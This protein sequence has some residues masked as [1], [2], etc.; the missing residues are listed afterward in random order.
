MSWVRIQIFGVLVAGWC[1]SSALV[2]AQDDSTA[3]APIAVDPVDVDAQVA[4]DR[5]G[6]GRLITEAKDATGADRAL[7]DSAFVTSIRIDDRAG[8]TTS[9]AEVLAETMGVNTR[10]LGGLG[11]FSS[12]SVRGASSGHT[13][14]SVDGVPLSRV[15]SASADLGRLSFASFDE[16]QLY[17]GAVPVEL[18][19]AALGGA[20]DLITPVGAPVSGEPW[21]LSM[22]GGS[23]GTRH[24]RARWLGGEAREHTGF[25]VSALYAGTNGDFSY[26]DDKGTNLI[27][28]DDEEVTRQN[29]GHDQAELVGRMR[30]ERGPWALEVGSRS[31]WRTQGL[32]GPGSVQAESASATTVGQTIDGKLSKSSLWGSSRLIGRASSFASFEWQHYQDR[33]GEVRLGVQDSRQWWLSTGVSGR[34]SI[35]AG[36]AHLISIGADGRFEIAAFS[37]AVTDSDVRGRGWR[38][39]SG[40]L[41]MDEI[42]LGAS[43]RIVLAPATRLDWMRTN[44]LGDV[45]QPVVGE[46][47]LMPRTDVFWSPRI[48]G[49]VRVLDGA[50]FK[51][52][53]GYYVRE[54]TVPELFG[55]RGVHVGNPTL[56]SERGISSDIGVIV[57]PS[58]S[59]G[60]LD[61]MYLESAAFWR[62]PRDTIVYR[63][64]IGGSFNLGDTSMIGTE[65]GGSIRVAKT[66]TLSAN[67]SWVKTR[68]DSTLPSYDGKPLPHAPEHQLYARLDIA[69]SLYQR[70]AVLWSDVSLTSGNYLD[71]AGLSPVPARRFIGLGMKLETLSKV[72]IGVEV[73]NITDEHIESVEYDPPPSPELAHVPRA[74]SDFY[75]YPLPG[76]AVYLTLEWKP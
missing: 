59:L 63:T 52:S 38:V 62:R 53:M 64:T 75:G 20:L 50:V 34:V 66:A 5:D 14:V 15:S 72:V 17:R 48:S 23:F 11:S 58:A 13:A 32:P 28:S 12:I 69:H 40:L 43:E 74:I 31:F 45:N 41:V 8:E 54:P 29:N 49:R 47:E 10:S 67:Y 27:L 51:G 30:Q 24:L 60:A 19:S 42:S 70:L 44:P 56:V 3:D 46:D 76:R 25:H 68:Q 57:A 33:E 21:T 22:G 6:L 16:V 73:K 65:I 71:L 18:G 36:D 39:G 37:D 9:V 7:N 61:R 1:S 26:Y 55:G 2:Y 35:D 4:R